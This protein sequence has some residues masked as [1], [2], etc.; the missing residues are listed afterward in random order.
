MAA[1]WIPGCQTW[2]RGALGPPA[3][4]IQAIG[5]ATRENFKQN[6]GGIS[7][8]IA[9]VTRH[10]PRSRLMK[11]FDSVR[12]GVAVVFAAMAGH[13]MAAAPS[14]TVLAVVQSANIDGVTGQ[15]VL[16]PEAP[17]YA[18]DRIDTGTV[19]QAQ[20]RFRDNTKIVVGPNSSM[21]ID[22]FIFDDDNTAREISLNVV[23]GAFRFITGNSR[24]DAYTITTPTATIGV[25]GTEFDVAVEREGT[26]RIANFEGETRICRRQ[27]NGDPIEGSCV[28]VSEP[29]SLSVIRPTERDVVQYSNDDPEFRNRQLEFYFPYVRSQTSLLSDFTVS[30]AACALA[31][32]PSEEHNNPAG[33]KPTPPPP[34]PIP[35]PDPPDLPPTVNPPAPPNVPAGR[36]LP[37]P[38]TR[39]PPVSRTH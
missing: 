20:I 10:P 5:I 24:K 2:R 23:K 32:A 30:L 19:G 12:F 7:F 16:Q 3:R 38:P 36:H 26:T 33:S 35:V 6:T 9:P 37:G 29:C 4:L 8:D 18:G 11:A 31:Q 25:R 13:A 34:T 39:N 1:L 14:G 22:A 17:V 28:A 21:V 15:Q 27:P